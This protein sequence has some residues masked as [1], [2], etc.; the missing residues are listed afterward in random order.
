MQQ[1]FNLILR[2]NVND[3]NCHHVMCINKW[4]RCH[5]T[6]NVH[7]EE[8]CTRSTAAVWKVMVCVGGD[9]TVVTEQ[10]QRFSW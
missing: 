8:M 5:T 10:D 7:T 4:R 6:R 3:T 9:S 1:E 2:L